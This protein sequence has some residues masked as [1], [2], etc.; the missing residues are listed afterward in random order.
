MPAS[1]LFCP[2]ISASVDQHSTYPPNKCTDPN[3]L[4]AESSTAGQKTATHIHSILESVTPVSETSC[5]RV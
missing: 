4:H 2:V 3:P 1:V 5:A